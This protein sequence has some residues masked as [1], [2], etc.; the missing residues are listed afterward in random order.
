MASSHAMRVRWIDRQC[1]KHGLTI[2]RPAS[3][4]GIGSQAES[5]PMVQAVNGDITTFSCRVGVSHVSREGDVRNSHGPLVTCGRIFLQA[6]HS[7]APAA[8]AAQ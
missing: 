4:R 8:Q 2:L 5:F 6:G 3:W 7:T 1:F